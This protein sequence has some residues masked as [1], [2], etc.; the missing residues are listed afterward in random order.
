MKMKH[1]Q[2][3]FSLI[4]MVLAIIILSVFCGV[5]LSVFSDVMQSTVKP[6]IID[7][8]TGLAEKEMDRVTGLRFSSVANE[9]STS[10]TGNFSNYSYKVDLSAVP[11]SLASDAGMALY[12]QVKVTVT[13]S[14]AGSV[15]LTTIVT[16]N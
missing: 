14:T 13:H 3:G 1:N 10:Y 9:A 16:N 8:S 15:S 4:E 5:V 12:K 2:K 7:V 11:L 6:E